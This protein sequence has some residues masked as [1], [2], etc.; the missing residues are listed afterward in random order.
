M[1]FLVAI[2]EVPTPQI[3]TRELE[4]LLDFF[5][6]K[7]YCVFHQPKPIENAAELIVAA[8]WPPEWV[9]RYVE[10]KYIV[11]DPTIRFLLRANRSFSWAQA[12][13]AYKDTPHY[14]RMKSMM[15]DGKGHG[16]ASGYIFPV[17]TRNGLIGA[18]TIGG[19]KEIELTQ[20]EVALLETAFR[21]AYLKYLEFMGEKHADSVAPGT[22]ITMTHREI[23]ALNNLAEG[24]TSPEIAQ[25]LDVSSNTVDWYVNSLQAKLQARNRNHAVALAFRQGLIT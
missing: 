11:T 3:L 18:T 15:A 24:R 23:Q 22:E 8:N 2:G 14:R 17:F 20:A 12:V 4:R 6:F 19:P 25:I 1:H 13:E 9:A 7:Y 10:K 5:G 21:N 16:L